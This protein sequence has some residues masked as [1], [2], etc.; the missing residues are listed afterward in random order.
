MGYRPRVVDSELVERLSSA[1]AVV[2]EGPKACGKTA[3][4]AQVASSEVRVDTD[5]NARKMAELDPAMLLDGSQPRLFDEWQFAP[6]IWN[7]VRRRIDDSGAQPG[8]FILTG[9]SLPND[10][11]NRHSGAGR[12]S[13]LTMRPM[14]LFESGHSSGDVSLLALMKAESQK[15]RDP[16]LTI[17][18]IAER[19]VVGGWPGHLNKSVANARRSNRD[20]VR[21]VRE[22]E[23]NQLLDGKKRDPVRVGQLL[24]SLGRNSATEVSRRSLALESGISETTVDDYLDAL[25]RV[26]VIEQ[27][28]A[29]SPSMSSAAALR[30]TP[31]RHFVDPSLAVATNDV[32]SPQTLLRELSH[33]GALFESLVVRD[34]R[35]L[36]Q[37]L[38]GSVFHYRDS[39]NLEVDAIVQC[40][41]SWAAFEIKLNPSQVDNGA[42][43]LKRLAKQV[44][45]NIWGEPACL[46]VITSTGFAYTRNDGVAVIPIG[47]LGP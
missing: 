34:L 44:N 41:S 19:I 45:T 38:G 13:F 23:V 24:K 33:M 36:S 14:S 43:A 10:E 35:V 8:Q 18:D 5:P 29:W 2:I 28:P 21:Q 15:A 7:H 37:P 12:F 26:M 1:G 32:A 30:K 17:S 47:A 31:K 39:N 3:T 20:Y 9:S 40:D 46:G 16:G 4:A 27:Q 11:I 22:V 42:K 6:E 25:V